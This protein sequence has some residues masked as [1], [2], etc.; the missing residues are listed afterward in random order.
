[1]EEEPV[2]LEDDQLNPVE[3]EPAD[4]P[5]MPTDAQNGDDQ[6]LTNRT[7]AETRV[8]RHLRDQPMKI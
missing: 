2:V 4:E 5:L 8:R 6:S 1:V 3:D 7:H